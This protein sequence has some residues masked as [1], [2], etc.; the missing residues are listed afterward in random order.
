MSWGHAVSKDLIHWKDLPVAIPEEKGIM[1][2]SGSAVLDSKNTAGFG[3]AKH[4]AVQ[5]Q[6]M[7][8]IYT[9]HTDSLQAQHLAYSNDGGI[10][11]TKYAGNP[12]LNLH[13]R[14]FRDP[15]VIWYEPGKEWIMSVSQPIEHQISFYASSNLKD[16][17]C[18]SIWSPRR[19][20]WGLGMSRFDASACSR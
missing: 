17:T 19:H 9:G 15:S 7:V 20:Q 3:D 5:D 1:I 18:G 12:V 11:W 10:S 8:A 14:D 2:F 4:S 13:K 16:W 6:A